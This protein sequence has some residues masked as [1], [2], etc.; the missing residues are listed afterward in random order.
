MPVEVK[1][2]LELRKALRAYAPDLAKQL[3]K[4]ISAAVKPVIRAAR[5]FIPSNDQMISGWVKGGGKFPA[6]DSSTAKRGIG[7]KTTPSK[8][9][10]RGFTSL[11]RLS[12]KSA[13][14]AIYETAGRKT[15]DSI[16][17]KNIQNKTAARMAGRGKE[18]GR[19]LFRAW[20]ADQG[21]ATVAVFKAIDNADKAFKS[22]TGGVK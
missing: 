22:R 16:F 13:A 4:E 8:P 18:Q 9:N 15:P 2:A 21:K 12:N 5:G 3:P 1:G 14:G 20:E 6:F 10:R 17:V 19:A 11:V 7:Y